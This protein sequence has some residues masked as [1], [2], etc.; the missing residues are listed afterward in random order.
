MESVS[1][2]LVAK[3]LKRVTGSIVGDESRY[4]NLRTVSSWPDRYLAE[5]QVGPLTALSVNDARTYPAIAGQ[6]SGTP[7]PSKDP[8]AYAADALTQLLRQRGVEVVGPA[9][10]GQT[11]SGGA[12]LAS[13]PSLPVR[14]IVREMLSYSDNNT[15]ELMLKEL[16]HHA[17]GQPGST[18]GGVAVVT[19]ALAKLSIPTAA[20]VMID[21]SGLDRGTRMSCSTLEAVLAVA[22]P[23][24]DLANGLAVAATS[25]TLADRY[26]RSPAAGKVRAKT[27]T[28]KDVSALSGWI[29]TTQ[30]RNV[31]F[32]VVF[33][34]DGR[35]VRDADLLLTQQIT[36]AALSYPDSPDLSA[37]VPGS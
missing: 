16:A 6:G 36:E 31:T 5:A 35:Q 22:G 12:T 3:G 25:G 10:A 15:A 11:P 32:S 30:G 18:A 37:L 13:V 7:Q 33:N 27:G 14:D 19:G 9:A 29:T 24:G 26:R 23:S 8:A 34:L 4:D 21:G 2:A 20:L 1:D 17:S 28:L